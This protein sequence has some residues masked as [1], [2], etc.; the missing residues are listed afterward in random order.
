MN[1]IFGIISR[2]NRPLSSMQFWN[3][4]T[5][6][7]QPDKN[8]F[9]LSEDGILLKMDQVHGTVECIDSL[10]S[11]NHSQSKSIIISTGRVDNISELA[12][13]LDISR[14]E[15]LAMSDQGWMQLAYDTWGESC[16]E[17]IYGDWA[18]AAWHPVE[19]RLFLARDH[20]GNTALYYYIDQQIF[21]FASSLQALLDLNLAPIEMDEL[22]LA[23]V[24]VSWQDYQGERTVHT[25]IRRLPPAHFLTITSDTFKTH[26]YWNPGET[27]PLHFKHRPDYVDAFQEVFDE[28]VRARLRAGNDSIGEDSPIA[29]TLSGGLDSSSVAVTAADFLRRDGKRL[30]AFTSIPLSNTKLYCGPHL[31][32]EFPLANITARYSG[33]IDLYAVDAAEITPIQAIRRALQILQ[34]PAHAAGNYFWIL[35]LAKTVHDYG[36]RILL[37]GQMGNAGVSWTG[38]A[39]SQPL[40]V[41]V[42]MLGMRNWCKQ[43]VKR[44][45]PHRYVSLIQKWRN[46][47]QVGNPSSAI[48]PD[49]TSR[50]QLVERRA[51]DPNEFAYYTP[52]QKRLSIM[53]FG[54]SITGAISDEIF[55]ACN[56]ESRD[57]TADVRVLEFISSVPDHIFID[58]K[59]GIDRWLIRAAMHNRLPD[60]V[61]LNRKRG[62]QA[63]DVVPRLRNSALEVESTLNELAHGPAAAYIDIMY[64]RKVW[65][66]ALSED[67]SDVFNKS[68][69]ILLRGIMAGLFVNDFYR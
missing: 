42:K 34:Q 26:R 18:L 46:Q 54:Q 36:C 44:S 40:A 23:Q 53:R 9:V 59:T 51:S 12:R 61:R 13:S 33:N 66:M 6:M 60:E 49:F 69:N 17:R 3:K 64:M 1:K 62:R 38:D 31:G 32:D 27:Q 19:R 21:A 35:Q 11:K 16:A 8:C 5:A 10:L 57:P 65:K 39:F 58:P 67:T 55:G 15:Q 68:Q 22:Y 63:G 29:V 4:L 37:T 30:Q 24:L 45:L 41:Q 47:G 14:S 20:F 7:S 56:I 50:M 48:H 2:N 43:K 25:P 52:L 28:S